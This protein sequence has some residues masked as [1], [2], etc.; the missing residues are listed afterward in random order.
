[1]PEGVSGA[2]HALHHAGVKEHF[3]AP[4]AAIHQHRDESYV[5]ALAHGPVLFA[6]PL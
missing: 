4:K 1:M 6:I 5:V 3:T 2:G